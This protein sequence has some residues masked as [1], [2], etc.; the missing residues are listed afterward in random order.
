M[1]AWL[2]EQR[3]EP[4]EHT[5]EQQI[6]M[7]NAAFEQAGHAS[8]PLSPSAKPDLL[9]GWKAA[10]E[11]LAALA[12][13]PDPSLLAELDRWLAEPPEVEMKALL[14][15]AVVPVV[16]TACIMALGTRVE[17]ERDERGRTHVKITRKDIS[18]AD[19]Q[20]VLD[21]L[22]AAVRHLVGMV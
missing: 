4:Q 19:L 15:V 16:L 11:L 10:R 3:P 13:T 9:A 1:T 14:E 5:T 18:G 7:L 8:V 12:Q 6:D 22:Y 17:F 21:R 20:N 2:D